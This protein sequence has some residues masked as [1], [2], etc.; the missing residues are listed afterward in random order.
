MSWGLEKIHWKRTK[1]NLYTVGHKE[2]EKDHHEMWDKVIKSSAQERG[3]CQRHYK[4]PI[5]EIGASRG[6]QGSSHLDLNLKGQSDFPD[7]RP[8]GRGRAQKKSNST[9]R[10]MKVMREPKKMSSE[11]IKDKENAEPHTWLAFFETTHF[12]RTRICLRESDHIQSD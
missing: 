9:Q 5:G 11:R 1:L 7:H 3:Q 4:D 10:N 8:A 2:V 6:T 12:V